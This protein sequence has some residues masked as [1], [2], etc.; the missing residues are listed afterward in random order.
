MK[1]HIAWIVLFATCALLLN[2]PAKGQA[3]PAASSTPVSAPAAADPALQADIATVTS[4]YRAYFLGPDYPDAGDILSQQKPDGSWPD[5]NYANKDVAAWNP[6]THI[7]RVKKMAGA[8]AKESSPFYHSAKMLAG[9][10]NGLR[11]WYA[12]KPKSKNW[13]FNDIGQQLQLERILV[14]LQHDL[15][16]DLMQTGLTYFKDVSKP[17]KA[18]GQNLVWFAGEYL[19]HGLL[20]GNETEIST[21]LRVIED[22][23]VITSE[24]GIQVDYSFHQHGPQLY[25]GGYGYGFLTDS[26]MYAAYTAGTRFAFPQDKIDLLSSY[27]LDGCRWMMRGSMFDYGANGRG[28]TRPPGAKAKRQERAVS[29][30]GAYCHQLADLNPS[31]KAEFDALFASMTGTGPVWPIL[32]NKQFWNSDFMVNQ[33]KPLYAS[34]KMNSSRTVGIETINGENLKGYWLPFGLTYLAPTG[35]EYVG[36]FPVWDWAHL[37]GVTSPAVVYKLKNNFKQPNAFVGGVSDGTHGACAMKLDIESPGESLHAHKSWFFFGDDF[38]ALGAGISSALDAPVDTTL[39]QTLLD[40]PVV[41]DGKT[42]AEGSHELTGVSWVLHHGIGY[43]F[44][45]KTDVDV[46]NQTQTGSWQSISSS[47]SPDPVSEKVFSLWVHHGV[48][49]TAGTYAYEVI[50]GAD[51]TKLAAY[52]A[53]NPVQILAN[54]TDLQAARDDALGVSQAIFYAPGQV[55]LKPGLTLAV[56]Q[57]CMVQITEGAG[58]AKVVLSSPTSGNTI[59]LTLGKQQISFDLPTG[60]MAGSSQSKDVPLS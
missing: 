14:L 4:R 21:A 47:T 54:T 1:N 20:T 27:C 33:S 11:F 16:P 13:W 48:K 40:G 17:T 38:L 7:E 5:V 9:V 43:L 53:K 23:I 3:P 55:T 58:T 39:N 35:R 46:N 42:V 24:E 34:V 2:T 29:E 31:R 52:A 32:G 12:A 45:A 57:P 51:S 56:D 10:E 60:N 28:L 59:H 37:P 15:P 30:V 44:P 49:P 26:S 36:I 41:V 25:N 19:T 22:T 6:N 18:T 8:Y 50:G